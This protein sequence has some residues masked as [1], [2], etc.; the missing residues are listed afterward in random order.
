LALKAFRSTASYDAAIATWLGNVVEGD[1]ELP[2]TLHLSAERVLNLRYGENPHQKGALYQLTGSTYG[3]EQVLGE[4][5]L[6][7]NNIQDLE[8]GAAVPL[9]FS[10]SC[11]CIIK[12]NT[13]CGLAVAS[14]AIEAYKAA[15][16]CDTVSAFGSVIATNR[17]IT[18]EFLDAVGKLFVEVFVAPKYSTDALEYL[19]KKKKN[20]RAMIAKEGKYTGLVV[21]SV[22]GGLLVQT[23]DDTGVK[24]ENWKVVSKKQPTEEQKKSLAFAWIAVKHTKSNAIVFVQGTATIGIGSGFPN[25]VD[26]VRFAAHQAGEKAKGCVMASDAFFPFPDSLEEGFKAGVVAVVHP[27]GSMRDDEVIEIADKL[28]LVLITT[29]ER[30]F[31]H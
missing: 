31:R 22:K 29:G 5:E 4:K 6:S 3:F 18:V 30:H 9:E 19:K 13:P 11:V 16:E 24:F 12:H 10:E 20:C 25:R 2:A 21:H 28:G 23:P 26:A 1:K 7:Y 14:N 27:G 8:A 17:E 15:F